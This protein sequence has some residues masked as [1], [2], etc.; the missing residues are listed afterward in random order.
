MAKNGEVFHQ[1]RR[2]HRSAELHGK[3]REGSLF[4]RREVAR[5]CGTH[6]HEGFS[7][8]LTGVLHADLSL[9]LAPFRVLGGRDAFLSDLFL[10][11]RQRRRRTRKS[12][13]QSCVRGLLLA[14][15]RQDSHIE[16]CAGMAVRRSEEFGSGR[17]NALFGEPAR[18]GQ[19]PP[20]FQAPCCFKEV[21][22]FLRTAIDQRGF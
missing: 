16:L 11:H 9:T 18:L 3:F 21:L 7:Q 2:N 17:R 13:L 6:F 22:C 19:Q 4:F 14:K 5:H 8:P 20:R 1:I 15:P 12:V 10:E